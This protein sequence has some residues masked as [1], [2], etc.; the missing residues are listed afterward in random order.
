MDPIT[1][2]ESAKTYI[3]QLCQSEGKAGLRLEVVGGGCA[4]FSYDYSFVDDNPADQTDVV[5]DLGNTKFVV[6]GT[7]LLYVIGT[8]VDY[9]KKIGQSGLVI[10]NPNAT[11]SC[12]CGESF[13][14]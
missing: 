6:D 2:S 3:E 5:I 9:E 10:K 14:I 12:G 8:I 11:S 13:G 1:V 4:G 7:S